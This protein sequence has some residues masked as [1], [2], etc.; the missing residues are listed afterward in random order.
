MK[1]QPI[2]QEVVSTPQSGPLCYAQE[3]DIIKSILNCYAKK[4]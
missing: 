2:P 4:Y 1:I 3:R